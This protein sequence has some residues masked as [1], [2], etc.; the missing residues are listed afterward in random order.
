VRTDAP[1]TPDAADAADLRDALVA[2]Y[3]ANA[4]D[5]PWRR[6]VSPWRTL[7]SELMLQQTRVDTVVPYFERFTARWPTVEAF[8]AATD[9]EVMEAWAG[10]GY[11]RRSRNLLAA[12]RAAAAAGGIPGDL[13]GLRALPGVGPYTA[14]A[15]ASIAFGLPVPAVDGNVERVLAR[16]D[17]WADDPR[18]AA[19]KRALAA[20]AGA[21][22]APGVASDV[23]QGLMELGATVCTPR[24]PSCGACPWAEPCVARARGQAASLPRLPAR[25]APVAVRGVA[26][27]VVDGSGRVLLGRR[28]PGL[29]GGLWEPVRGDL[30]DD[31]HGATALTAAA[32]ALLHAE[33]GLESAGGR[34]LGSVVHVFTHRR[35]SLEVVTLTA[36]GAPRDGGPT[37]YEAWV[38][39]LPDGHGLGLSRLADKVLAL[40]AAREAQG[41]A[42]LP[43]LAAEP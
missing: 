37:G 39:A 4:R 25:K 21:L 29:L 1:L 5:L 28:P 14:G 15:I 9:A 11:Y 24:G 12:A 10:L 43:L 42:Q 16:V 23:T 22:T 35:L 6:E 40:W 7:L 34:H 19:G 17:G 36:R 20:R 8:A 13:E 18:T 38:W 30:P 2:W 33:T 32:G 31:V 26:A 3:R 27:V 41:G